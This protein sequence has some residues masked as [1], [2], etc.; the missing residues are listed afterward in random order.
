MGTLLAVGSGK[1]TPDCMTEIFRTA[2]RKSAGPSAPPKGLSLLGVR[3][4]DWKTP[5]EGVPLT[6][7]WD[8]KPLVF[9]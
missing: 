5:L 2:D 9:C 1:M 8:K 6:A 3:Y 4:E 7:L